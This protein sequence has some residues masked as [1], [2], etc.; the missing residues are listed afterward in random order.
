MIP[1]AHKPEH[2]RVIGERLG[3]P[4]MH[5][6]SRGGLAGTGLTLQELGSFGIR[7]VADTGTALLAGYAAWKQVYADLADGFGANAKPA[8][9]WSALEKDM[10]GVIGLEK[11]L[12]IERA[13]VETEAKAP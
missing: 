12:E 5:L 8:T 7:I 1:M 10:L 13:T 2:L 9:D 4:L 11:F 6:A 3:G